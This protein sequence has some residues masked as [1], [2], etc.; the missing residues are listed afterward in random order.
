MTKGHT[1]HGDTAYIL[2]S[3]RWRSQNCCWLPLLY[4]KFLLEDKIESWFFA[5][6][7]TTS[8]FGLVVTM[9]MRDAYYSKI[10]KSILIDFIEFLKIDFKKSIV[11]KSIFARLMEFWPIFINFALFSLVVSLIFVFNAAFFKDQFFSFFFKDNFKW[12]IK[13]VFRK[14]V[15][16]SI[17]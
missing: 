7:Q 4:Q 13:L 15:E 6:S 10:S 5:G 14:S 16:K 17:F 2:L 1:S 3:L 9:V 12:L 8:R 11:K